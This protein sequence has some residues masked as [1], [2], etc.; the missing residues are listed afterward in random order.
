MLHSYK[1]WLST[2]FRKCNLQT[3]N[4]L[5]LFFESKIHQHLCL[6]TPFCTH[7]NNFASFTILRDSHMTK[8]TI[9]F[10]KARTSCV[11]LNA[12]LALPLDPQHVWGNLL[13]LGGFIFTLRSLLCIFSTQVCNIMCFFPKCLHSMSKAMCH[14]VIVNKYRKQMRSKLTPW[15]IPLITEALFQLTLSQQPFELLHLKCFQSL[16]ELD[17]H[18]HNL[19]FSAPVSGGLQCRKLC[20]SPVKQH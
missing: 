8:F 9:K 4:Q 14:L 19:T 16:H 6:Q 15:G 17:L 3:C 1:P 10:N 2:K 7:N 20:L 12:V 5:T 13:L 18:S 11:G